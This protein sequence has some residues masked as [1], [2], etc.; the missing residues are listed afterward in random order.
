MKSIIIILIILFPILS[1]SQYNGNTLYENFFLRQPSARAEAMGRGYCSLEGDLSSVFYNPAGISTINKIEINGT[2]SMA[3]LYFLPKAKDIFTNIGY[4]YN[5]YLTMAMTRRRFTYGQDI[6]I[7][8]L[9]GNIV[10]S[11]RLHTTNITFTLASEPIKNLFIGLNTNYYNFYNYSSLSDLKPIF[12]FD[13]GAIKKFNLCKNYNI[14]HS[15]NIGASLTNFSNVKFTDNNYTF[16]LP[17]ISRFGASYQI[18]INKPL[19]NDS[20][21]TLKITIL[22][23]YQKL[24]N[25]KYLSGPHSGIEVLFLE[26]ICLRAG[27]YNESIDTYNAPEDEVKKRINIF[28]Y[29]FGFQLPLNKITKLPLN[30]KFDYTSLPQKSHY[31]DNRFQPGNFTT[32]NLSISW[33]PKK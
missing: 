4:K 13:F 30:I 11:V 5:K 26:M 18:Y 33:I 3:N 7:V 15:L 22:G 6:D 21:R 12:Y 9:N 28:T 25:Y 2:L 17:V 23:E 1:F 8:D 20:L 31:S 27:Y 14:K 19:L 24:F 29:G 16:Y 32:Y 10:E